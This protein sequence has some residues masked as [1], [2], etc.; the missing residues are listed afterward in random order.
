MFLADVSDRDG[1]GTPDT[2][3][4]PE[5]AKHHESDADD[6]IPPTPEAE[7]KKVRKR[8]RKTK[9]KTYMDEEGYLCKYGSAST[10][11]LL[12]GCL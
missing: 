6:V 9:D 1:S 7:L 4:P 2:S 8:V 10:E 11:V 5:V 3:P 12:A